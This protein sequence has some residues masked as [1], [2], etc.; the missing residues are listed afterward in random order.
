VDLQSQYVSLIHG[1]RRVFRRHP[2]RQWMERFGR[3]LLDKG[4]LSVSSFDWSGGLVRGFRTTDAPRYAAALAQE[5]RRARNANAPLSIVTKS[6]GG[7]IAEKALLLLG[8]EVQV[9]TLLRIG[10]PDARKSPRLP[11]VSRVVNVTSKSDRLRPLGTWF[12]PFFVSNHA[13]YAMPHVENVALRA[14]NHF[15][16][17]ELMPLREDA[18]ADATTYDLYWRLLNQRVANIAT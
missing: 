18:I 7:L 8:D 13:V 17:T 9:D 14:P 15:E 10:V 5:Y 6:L 3:F 2:N 4:A 1:V 12:V 11:N 16:L